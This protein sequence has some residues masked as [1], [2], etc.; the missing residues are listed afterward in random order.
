MVASL[1]AARVWAVQGAKMGLLVLLGL[2][3]LPLLAGFF[4]ELLMLPLKC[5]PSRV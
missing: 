3:L 5:A 2:G 1:V 4:T